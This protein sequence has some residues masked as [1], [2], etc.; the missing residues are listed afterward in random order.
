ML[1]RIFGPK[2]D[3][4]TRE[5]GQLHYKEI[6]DLHSSP[7]IVQVVKSRRMTCVG[8]VA[9]MGEIEV[10]KG[11]GWGNFKERDDLEDPGLD[12]MIIFR[13]IFRKWAVRIRIGSIWLR[14][15]TGGQHLCL[16]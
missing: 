11:F 7:N 9:H 4:V 13:W 15:R 10:Y 8:H 1:K 2:R 6:N 14:I 12:G 16:R 3:E 5:W